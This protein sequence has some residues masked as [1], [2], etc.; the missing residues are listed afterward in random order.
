[1][2]LPPPPATVSGSTTVNAPT[3][4]RTAHSDVEATAKA[5]RNA[6]AVGHRR[7]LAGD[8]H[9]A[10]TLEDLGRF[11]VHAHSRD[12]GRVDVQL[13]ADRR[14]GAAMLD[15]HAAELRADVRVEVPR[16]F[17]TVETS[18]GEAPMGT[19][20]RSNGRETEARDDRAERRAE[21]GAHLTSEPTTPAREA[22]SN[23]RSARVRIVL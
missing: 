16:A 18:T 19:P 23:R 20:T 15:A 2:V 7:V 14:E 22:S 10:L 8:A 4:I 12:D 5:I 17:I 13:R 1:M 21:H 6:E 9:G 3:V 11:E